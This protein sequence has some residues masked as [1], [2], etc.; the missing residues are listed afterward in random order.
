MYTVTPC[1]KINLGLNITEK[2]PDGYHNLETVFY[3]VPLFDRI[4]IRENGTPE[5]T[6]SL[7]MEG[8]EIEGNP[9]E[10]LVVKAYREMCRIKPLPGVEISLRKNIPT[11]AG[12]GGGSADCAYTLTALNSMFGM[13]LPASRMEE[14]AARLGADCAFF[15]K[16]EPC[17]ATGIGDMMQPVRLNLD[18]YWI[19]VVKPP[20]S[21]STKEAFSGIRPQKPP[22]CCREIIEEE[23]MEKWRGLLHNDFEKTI[24]KIHPELSAVKE[25]L[26]AEGAV[27][28]AMSGSG[29]ALFGLFNNKPQNINTQTFSIDGCRIETASLRGM[30]EQFPIVSEKGDTVGKTCRNYAHSGMKP[31][32]P[33]VHL[34]VF[35]SRGELYLQKRPEWKDIQ[36]GKWDTA[37]GGHI[38]AGETVEE[39]LHRETAEE[40]G[41]SD[42]TAEKMCSYA[43][44]SDKEK[45]YVN[46]FRTIYDKPLHPSGSELDGGRFFSREEIM[47]NIGKGM[48]TPNFEK[49]WQKLF[50]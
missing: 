43:F 4:T 16:S 45:E 29:S 49:E 15:V 21:V 13:G 8:I 20:I 41:I 18:K 32:H 11:Q 26:Y 3:P 1:A 5:G 42:Y 17:F 14:I 9:E 6:C 7:L 44:E 12:M 37:V 28:A 27:Y 50:G 35:N 39:A 47:Q 31:L 46:V 36:P 2:R 40:I 48:F 24:F 23:P 19:V 34:H 10:N 25:K 30:A 38:D 33:V 22:R